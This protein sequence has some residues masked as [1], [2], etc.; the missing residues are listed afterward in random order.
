MLDKFRMPILFK[1]FLGRIIFP[2]FY[3]CLQ[4]RLEMK[5]P[6][7]TSFLFQT[8]EPHTDKEA[9]QAQITFECTLSVLEISK[10][11]KVLLKE[12]LRR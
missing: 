1:I 9:A 7:M 2:R 12:L 5:C 6:T 8:T 10:A 4:N 3:D 11:E